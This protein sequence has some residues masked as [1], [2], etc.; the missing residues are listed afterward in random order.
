M[1]RWQNG[2]WLIRDL[3]SR[4]GT[5]IDDVPIAA[6]ASHALS[7]GQALVFGMAEERWQVVDTSAPAPC[8][9]ALDASERRWGAGSLLLLPSD[10]EPEASVYLEPVG[11]KLEQAGVSR[12]LKSGE[13]IT[14]S[15]HGWR[16]L[17]PESGD[18]SSTTTIGS[19]TFSEAIELAFK[20]SP[21]EERVELTLRQG[22]VVRSL[23]SRA[24]LYTLLTLA[25][26]RL[27]GTEDE[28]ERGWLAPQALADLLK[29]APERVHV[30]FHRIRRLFQE[31]GLRE[32]LSI[33]QRH[34]D[35][36][37]VRIGIGRLS[38]EKL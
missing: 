21:D 2:R 16:L 26:V 3:A 19:P 8:A 33:I 38:I 22:N 4:N 18:G 32:G 24:C 27:E 28:P 13:V 37:R 7:V 9:V 29:V 25:R 6:R 15:G 1:I 14:I 36:R 11:W 5:S 23:P 20:V 10:E 31:A 12:P 17:L 35:A 30:D 34:E